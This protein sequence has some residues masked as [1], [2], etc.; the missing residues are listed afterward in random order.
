MEDDERMDIISLILYIDA[1]LWQLKAC[2]RKR[3]LNCEGMI[4]GLLREP[5]APPLDQRFAPWCRK[6]RV[7]RERSVLSQSPS[8]GAGAVFR[9]MRGALESECVPATRQV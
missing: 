2:L 6:C 8:H 4:K 5:L 1:G 3:Q 7:L 9:W